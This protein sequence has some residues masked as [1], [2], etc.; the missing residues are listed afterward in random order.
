MLYKERNR[1][2]GWLNVHDGFQQKFVFFRK[3]MVCRQT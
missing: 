1:S 2:V 3:I